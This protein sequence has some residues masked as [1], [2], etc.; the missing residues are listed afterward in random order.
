MSDDAWLARKIEAWYR[1]AYD[2]VWKAGGYPDSMLDS[3]PTDLIVNL[4]RNDIH[5]VYKGDDGDE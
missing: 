4:A 2:A 1:A 3:M 5:F